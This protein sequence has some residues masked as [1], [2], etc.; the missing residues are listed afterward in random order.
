MSEQVNRVEERPGPNRWKDYSSQYWSP[1]VPMLL[2]KLSS[3]MEPMH[4]KK[5][6]SL[7][8]PT[9]FKKLWSPTI[10]MNFKKSSLQW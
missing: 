2:K 8:V 6:W 10:P 4:F 5:L 7:M 9:H 3:P 1:M